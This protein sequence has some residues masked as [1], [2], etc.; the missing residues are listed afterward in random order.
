MPGASG[1]MWRSRKLG[2]KEGNTEAVV[3]GLGLGVRRN[4]PN[5]DTENRLMDE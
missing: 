5:T 1:R 3:L 4:R 2:T